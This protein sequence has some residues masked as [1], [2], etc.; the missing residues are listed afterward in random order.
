MAFVRLEFGGPVAR[1]TLDNDAGNRINFAMRVEL[2][3][4]VACIAR[5][6]VRAPPGNR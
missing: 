5:S 3:D 1:I 4:A 2:R 6:D